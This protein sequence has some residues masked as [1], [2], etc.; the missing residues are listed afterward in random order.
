M[1]QNMLRLG[2]FPH[3]E[4]VESLEVKHLPVSP[5]ESKEKYEVELVGE[6]VDADVSEESSVYSWL[7]WLVLV[8][9]VCGSV[10][11]VSVYKRCSRQDF[12]KKFN[13][14]QR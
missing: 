11:C 2:A 9:L 12:Q 14:V 6:C 7:L 10:Y 8:L 13:A 4:N 5:F 3:L 1:P